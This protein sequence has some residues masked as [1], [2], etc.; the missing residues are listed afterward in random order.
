MR[1]ADSNVFVHAFLKPRRDLSES[2][3]KL[4]EDAKKIVSR[5]NSGEKVMTS[6][7]HIAEIANI[8]EDNL[9]AGASQEILRSLLMNEHLEIDSVSR[10]DCLSAMGEMEEHSLGLNDSI[11]HAVM[12]RNGLVEIYSFDKDFDRLDDVTRVSR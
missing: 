7:V 5:V 8:L 3:K 11:A 1:F 12:R 10:E 9:E 6:V 4:K 2:E